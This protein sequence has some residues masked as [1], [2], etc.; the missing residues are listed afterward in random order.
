MV[1]VNLLLV[2]SLKIGITSAVFKLSVNI[3]VL[4]SLLS[5]EGIILIASIDCLAINV[6]MLEGLTSN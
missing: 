4:S 3:P 2:S 6:R 5:S 1:I